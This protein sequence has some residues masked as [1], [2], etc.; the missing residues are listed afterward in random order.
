ML[1]IMIEDS[2]FLLLPQCDLS[3]KV[4]RQ[5]IENETL[6]AVFVYSFLSEVY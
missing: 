6:S 3:E 4:G 1:R 2:H 5:L